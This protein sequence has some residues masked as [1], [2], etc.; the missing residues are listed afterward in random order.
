MEPKIVECGASRCH[1]KES[2]E[3]S[4]LSH[5]PHRVQLRQREALAATAESAPMPR[6]AFQ[7]PLGHLYALLRGSE[8]QN[9]KNAK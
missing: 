2:A 1:L 6:L 3:Q 5:R 7:R 4:R 9:A 8:A